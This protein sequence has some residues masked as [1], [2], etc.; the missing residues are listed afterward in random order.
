MQQRQLIGRIAG[1]KD[2]RNAGL[3]GQRIGNRHTTRI[4]FDIQVFQTD[5]VHIWTAATAAKAY[6]AWN[7]PFSPSCSQ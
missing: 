7:T 2:M 3:H 5:I 4:F 6:S 1:D